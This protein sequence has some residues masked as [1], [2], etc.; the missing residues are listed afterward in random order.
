MPYT[1]LLPIKTLDQFVIETEKLFDAIVND[2]ADILFMRRYRPLIKK[3]WDD[4]KFRS[5]IQGT[6]MIDRIKTD[7]KNAAQGTWDAVGLWGVQLNAKLELL[8]DIWRTFWEFGTIDWLEELL[9]TINDIFGSFIKVVPLA[10][11]WDELKKMIERMIK[12]DRHI[13]PDVSATP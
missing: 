11:A 1:A 4:I 2:W 5:A 7:A 8:N 3:A 6:T 12:M 9:G 10:E 13:A